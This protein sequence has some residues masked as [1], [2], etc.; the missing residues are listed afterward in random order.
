MSTDPAMSKRI[1]ATATPLQPHPGRSEEGS[2]AAS[3][4]FLS[5]AASMA[6]RRR[7]SLL[8][9]V[10]GIAAVVLSITT[11]IGTLLQHREAAQTRYLQ[12]ARNEVRML[13]HMIDVSKDKPVDQ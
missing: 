8:A 9:F 5:F 4:S 3:A 2:S 6:M 7:L 10:L 1:D 13:V 11:V 12:T